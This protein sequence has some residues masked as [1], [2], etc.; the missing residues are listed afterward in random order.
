LRRDESARY[1]SSTELALMRAIKR[2]LDPDNLM[3]HGKVLP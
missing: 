2:A 3:N 1:K